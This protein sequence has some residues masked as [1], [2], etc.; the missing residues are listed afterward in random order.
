MGS[1]KRPRRYSFAM[2]RMT[3]D[4]CGACCKGLL[5]VEAD[6]VDLLREPRLKGADPYY[7]GMSSDEVLNL[8]MADTGRAII[9]TCGTERPCP[10]LDAES[11]CTIYPTRPNACVAMQ[12]GD[13]QCEQARIEIG[14]E[15]LMQK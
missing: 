14:L 4:G 6:V 2:E 7:S 11:K 5:I 10:F 3:C 15:K 8:F 9:L 13:D 12:A 1:V